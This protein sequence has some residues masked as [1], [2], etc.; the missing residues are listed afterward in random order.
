MFSEKIKRI[1]LETKEELKPLISNL[2]W[3][4]L[5]KHN[6]GNL[7][8]RNYP[9]GHLDLEVIRYIKTV[10]YINANF[11]RYSSVLDIGFFVP[12][13]PI[14]LSKLGFRVFAL[15][16]LCYYNGALDN[17]INFAREKYGVNIL[18]F[19]ILNDTIPKSW[20]TY[21]VVLLLAVLEHLNGTPK[22]VLDK[23]KALLNPTGFLIV[24][25][26]NAAALAKRLSFLLK[27]KPPFPPF[28]DYY[29]SEYPFSG[30]NREYTIQD[31]KYALE[32]SG[33][34]IVK[35]EVFH[36]TVRNILSWKGRLLRALERS[37][38]PS[39]KPS[40]WTVARMLKK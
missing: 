4:K 19:D 32:R 35:I 31:V 3:E 2:D 17:I 38:P 27:G 21:D 36:H 25:V 9:S 39:W 8:Y 33:F 40:I 22:Y 20:E 13:I 1:V 16:K 37:G 34:E 30:H 24:E 7:R 11:Q 18:D 29:D 23:V 10:D 5:S 28:E 12:L 6:K 14:A 15:E 26:P